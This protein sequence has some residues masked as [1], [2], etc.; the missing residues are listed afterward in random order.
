MLWLLN[1]SCHSSLG[2]SDVRLL[3][4]VQT[5]EWG[6]HVYVRSLFW[7]K[8]CTG[9]G[10]TGTWAIWDCEADSGKLGVSS[11]RSP[12]RWLGMA[13]QLL[14][15]QNDGTKECISVQ[16]FPVKPMKLKWIW[17]KNPYKCLFSMG[18]SSTPPAAAVRGSFS[19]AKLSRQ[20]IQKNLSSAKNEKG[21]G[22]Q[23]AWSHTTHSK[24]GG[25]GTALLWGNSHADFQIQQ[26]AN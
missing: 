14:E 12:W 13:K 2:V 6:E 4:C 1:I 21:W 10:K 20:V 11:G 17:V 3:K 19:W 24:K 16:L 25:K 7:G 26:F 23:G 18:S 8:N 22:K 9:Q 15:F 5:K